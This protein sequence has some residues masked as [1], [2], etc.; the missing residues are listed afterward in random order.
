L[1]VVPDCFTADQLAALGRQ[2]A[3]VQ[4]DQQALLDS[5]G[6]ALEETRRVALEA[7]L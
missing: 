7:S 4:Y 1:P 3:Q 6:L 5:I 2:S